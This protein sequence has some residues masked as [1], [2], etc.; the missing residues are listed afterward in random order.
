[1][2]Q[3]GNPS[4]TSVASRFYTSCLGIKQ[5]RNTHIICYLSLKFFTQMGVAT[6]EIGLAGGCD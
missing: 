3:Y 1:M 6:K 5:L 2:S 4:Q